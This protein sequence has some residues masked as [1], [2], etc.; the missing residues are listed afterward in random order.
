MAGGDA[1][2]A[3]LCPTPRAHRSVPFAHCIRW[4]WLQWPGPIQEGS[5]GLPFCIQLWLDSLH[6][7]NYI[8]IIITATNIRI[9][10]ESTGNKLF[11][12]NLGLLSA[13]NRSDRWRR[14]V[15][16]VCMACMTLHEDQPVRPMSKTS[17]TGHHPELKLS[18]LDPGDNPWLK[19]INTIENNECHDA[20][21]TIETFNCKGNTM[22]WCMSVL[23]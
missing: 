15:R 5:V 3:A 13:H 10:E 8:K 21:L 11:R 2:A 20:W 16:P 18:V 19:F 6:F 1:Q 22:T 9:I 12:H 17:Q 7:S 4:A 14:P 23:R